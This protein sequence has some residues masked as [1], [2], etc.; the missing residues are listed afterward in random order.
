M[1]FAQAIDS[2]P[3]SFWKN[4]CM[5][6]AAIIVI[7]CGVVVAWATARKPEPTRLND[8][9]AIKVE[10]VSKRYNHDAVEQRFGRIETRIDGHDS[11]L[12]AAWEEMQRMNAENN[13]TNLEVAVSLARLETHFGLNRSAEKKS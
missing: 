3:A 2:L 4:F 8:E 1:M 10:K 7:G 11:E 6:L 12:N 13:K 9:P 5:A